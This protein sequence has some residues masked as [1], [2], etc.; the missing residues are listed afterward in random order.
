MKCVVLAA[1]KSIRLREI[2][3]DVPK[4]LVKISGISMIERCISNLRRNGFDD[5][6]V[7]VHYKP[8]LFEQLLG[9]GKSLGVNITYSYEEQLLDTAGSLK[10]IENELQEDFFVCGGSFLLEDI[11]LQSVIATQK[12]SKNIL[13]VVLNKCN[14]AEILPFYGQALVEHNKI[15]KFI[16]KP[17]VSFS[18][19]IHTT[20]QVISPRIFDFIE[21]GEK[22]AIPQL[23]SEL[24][25]NGYNVG[26]YITETDLI[27]ISSPMLYNRA[28]KKL[29]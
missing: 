1:G 17:R 23:I 24:V 8:E 16:E 5:I 11:D 14:D 2:T 22:K 26:G 10:N 27:N 19:L 13:T 21:K 9:N 12:Y 28:I 6:I 20:Y 25:S 3:G 29:L 7:T 15:V 18:N 4:P